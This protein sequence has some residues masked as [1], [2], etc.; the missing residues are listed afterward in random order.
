MNNYFDKAKVNWN[1]WTPQDIIFKSNSLVKK[2]VPQENVLSYK[3]KSDRDVQ[4]CKLTNGKAY[5]NNYH[6]STY[7]GRENYRAVHVWLKDMKSEYPIA[8]LDFID[9]RPRKDSVGNN[10]SCVDALIYI[11]SFHQPWTW[12]RD[13]NGNYVRV[14][15]G[16]P[17]PLDEGYRFCYGGQGDS[18]PMSHIQFQEILDI[19]ESVRRFLIDVVVPFRN[20]EDIGMVA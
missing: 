19:T 11:Q 1:T 3:S 14:S 9:Y 13:Q 15:N 7:H 12:Q 6:N 4:M 10:I 5:T 17:A 16:N 20:G 2:L 18:N 8:N